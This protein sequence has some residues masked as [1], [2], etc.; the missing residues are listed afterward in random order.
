V[1]ALLLALLLPGALRAAG[2]RPERVV[3]RTDAGD[4]EVALYA[5]APRHARKLLSLFSS[6]AY[7]TAPLFKVDAARFVHVGGVGRRLVPP[8]PEALSRIKRLPP[9]PGAAPHRAGVLSMAHDA[10]DPDPLETSFV[11]LLADLPAM[12]GRFT[13]VGEVTAGGAVLDAL[14]SARVDAAGAPLRPL[15]VRRT[16]VLEAGAPAPALRGPDRAALGLDED[17]AFRRRLLALAALA[18]AAA[19]ALWL[20]RARLGRGAG[21]AALLCALGA[22]FGAFAGSADLAPRAR[23]LG[24]LLFVSAIGCFRLMNEFE[25]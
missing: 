9:E 12:D 20:G 1:R 23:W 13:A 22:F 25:R 5:G 16:E 17:E 14:R 10:A 7:D 11:I 15:L 2:L 3:L 24:P 4:L 21:A 8:A 19:A 18:A 6:G